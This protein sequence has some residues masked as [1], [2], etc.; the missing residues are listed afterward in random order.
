[1]ANRKSVAAG[2]F[3]EAIEHRIDDLLTEEARIRGVAVPVESGRK[4]RM[5]Y[6]IDSEGTASRATLPTIDPLGEV[7]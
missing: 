6:F 2:I 5:V 7:C 4:P 3:R 1:M